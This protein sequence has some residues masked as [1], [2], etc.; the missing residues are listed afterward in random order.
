M[1]NTRFIWIVLADICLN[2]GMIWLFYHWQVSR[3][4]GAYRDLCRDARVIC[5]QVRQLEEESV[6]REE[7]I[8]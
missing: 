6:R 3:R 4:R 2:L 8:S 5:Q 7:A 1:T